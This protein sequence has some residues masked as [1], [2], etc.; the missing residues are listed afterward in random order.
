V[1]PLVARTDQPYAFTNDDPLNATDPLGLKGWYCDNGKSV[2]YK[3]N[4]ISDFGT[5]RCSQP[6]AAMQEIVAA[7]ATSS[8]AAALAP[9]VHS[10]VNQYTSNAGGCANNSC[11]PSTVIVPSVM[12]PTVGA[13]ALTLGLLAA[14]EEVSA[15]DLASQSALENSRFF[16]GATG[17]SGD[18]YGCLQTRS[19]SACTT[20]AA[21]TA[22][23]VTDPYASLAFGGYSLA[24]DLFHALVGG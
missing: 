16:M 10:A 21:A 14:P 22:S 6:G 11:N 9:A 8:Q 18:M 5:G 13:T 17:A 12:F 1:D 20:G 3:G 7:T 15:A 24:V 19:I 2:Y 23:V 4:S